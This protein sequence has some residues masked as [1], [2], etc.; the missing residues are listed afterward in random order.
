MRPPTSPLPP[1]PTFLNDAAMVFLRTA[2]LAAFLCLLYLVFANERTGFILLGGLSAASIA[3]G[4]TVVLAYRQD[5]VIEAAPEGVPEVRAVR[6]SPLPLPSGTPVAGVAAL[7]LLATGL[8]YGVSLIVVGVIVGLLTLL[9]VTAVLAGEHRGV[10]VSLLPLTI[11]LVAFAVIGS[12][13]FVMSRILLA[14]NHD[15]SVVVGI[16]VAILIL[17]GGFFIANAPQVAT[18][19]LVRAGAGLAIL[20]AAGGLAAYGVGQRAE[21]RKAGP[22]AVTEIARNISFVTKEIKAPAGAAITV[23]FKNEDVNVP[24]NMDFTVDQAGSQSFYKKDPLPGPIT[25]TYSFTA[26]KA[27][28]YYYHCDVH[29]NMTGT[30]LVTGS[31]GGE[32]GQAATPTTAGG[33]SKT[34]ETTAVNETT[35]TAAKAASGGGAGGTSANLAAKNISYLQKTLTLKANSPVVIH[36]DNQDAGIPHNVDITTDPGGSNTLYKQDPVAGPIQSDY[37]FTTPGPGKLYYHC[38]VHPNMTGTINVQ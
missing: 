11:P 19:T 25:S 3:A 2:G 31:G 30:L 26:P 18:R 1:R 27:G 6:F 38:D 10:P 17:S 33:T 5:L 4:V 28:T 37:K 7:V 35:T 16:G 23:D 15:V 8:L 22:P 34:S 21:E 13:M 14:V 12:F 36:F 9:V 29:P 24:H 32:P 20:F